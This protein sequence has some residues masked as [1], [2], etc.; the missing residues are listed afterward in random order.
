M[1]LAT[2]D[3]LTTAVL[4]TIPMPASISSNLDKQV[5]RALVGQN[6]VTAARQFPNIAVEGYALTKD[7]N[8]KNTIVL[9]VLAQT[10]EQLVLSGILKRGSDRAILASL[11]ANKS[12]E[13]IIPQSLFTGKHEVNSVS[14]F[15]RSINAQVRSKI[16][17]FKYCLEEL[18]KREVIT[19]NEEVTYLAGILNVAANTNI[20][21]TIEAKKEGKI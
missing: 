10:P 12:L 15:L 11:N 17:L 7:Y 6:A 16:D 13:A 4:N 2:S 5:T 21:I 14:Q 19:G 9:G 18:I 8:D 20:D 1:T 3:L